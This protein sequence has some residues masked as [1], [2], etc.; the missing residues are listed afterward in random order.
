MGYLPE[1]METTKGRE[2]IDAFV[3]YDARARIPE[4]A[5]SDMKNMSSS[6]YPVL[7]PRG[8]RGTLTLL[9]DPNGITAKSN[10]FWV[11]GRKLYHNG[12]LV[13]NLTL[14]DS[15]KQFV[16][17]GAYL[18]IWPDKIMYDTV[19]KKAENLGASITI[20]GDVVCT[21]TKQDGTAYPTPTVSSTEPSD[22]DDGDTWL[23]TSETTHVLKQYS[24]SSGTWAPV[25]T[26]YVKI[27]AT[28]I[29]KQFKQYDGVTISGFTTAENL[30]GDFILQGAA[31]NHIIVIGLLDALVEQEGGVTV[32]RKIPDMDFLTECEN[33]VWGC[34]STNHEI[35]ACKQGDPKNWYCYMGVAT[36]SYAATVGSDGDFTGAATYFGQVLF[37]KEDML[38]KVVGSHPAN[39]QISYIPCRGV[40]K[41]SE[42]SLALVNERLYYKARTAICVYDG[43]M[44]ATISDELGDTRYTKAVAGGLGN[45]YYISM[46]GTDENKTWHMFVYDTVLGLWHREDNTK[47]MQFTAHEGELFYIDATTKKIMS[48]NGRLSVAQ[49]GTQYSKEHG[50]TE[51]DVS[52]EVE[53]GDLGLN[54]PDHK[55]ISRLLIRLSVEEETDI[56]LSLQFDS[57]G[58]WRDYTLKVT[59]PLKTV[60]LPV[61]VRR[62]DHL[63]MKIAGT[64]PC[65]IYSITKTVEVGGD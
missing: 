30:N 15:E 21:L 57:S 29:G 44:P 23:D 16:S 56:V 10:L 51:G 4:N 49:D 8:K 11:D 19:N 55:Y 18:L 17:M 7:S 13:T 36:D 27:A 12:T 14:T 33:R 47:A 40:E 39:Y 50:A 38:H 9:S 65:K 2:V 31:K 63:R 64:K 22:P 46:Q 28:N 58:T 32:E 35:Y 45:K 60:K 26:T 62:C 6:L 24:A 25:P 41:G 61:Y 34:S 52:W 59:T 53:S 43:A 54:L 5:F 37:F 48:V 1:M 42:K 3:G 20:T